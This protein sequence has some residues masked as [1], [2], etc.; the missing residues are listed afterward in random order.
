MKLGEL[1]FAC[2]V[3]DHLDNHKY[4]LLLKVTGGCP[5][6]CNTDHRI[7]LLEWLNDWGCRHISIK[8]HNSA[9]EQID[10]WYEEFGSKIPDENVDLLDLTDEDLISVGNAHENL[11]N[12]TAAY[13]MINGQENAVRFGTTAASKILFAIRPKSIPL[14]DS[15]IQQNLREIY[16]TNSYLDYIRHVKGLIE[17]LERD[18]KKQRFSL[19][20]LPQRLNRPNSTVPKLIDEYYWVT[21]TREWSLPDKKTLQQ[22]ADWST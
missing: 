10:E 5:D 1:A 19:N 8:Y 18:C 4:E 22:W 3:F 6:V 21:I 2:Y 12:R 20:E 15:P 14:W 11:S 7:A 17:D 16:S 13:R 9:S